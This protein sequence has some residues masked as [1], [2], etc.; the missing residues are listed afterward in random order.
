MS[1]AHWLAMGPIL[2]LW[3]MAALTPRE[4]Q[5]GGYL[6]A[7]TTITLAQLV[8]AL[9]MSAAIRLPRFQA[10]PDWLSLQLAILVFTGA[11]LLAA[12]RYERG[13]LV[14]ASPALLRD[15]WLATASDSW[16]LGS[17]AGNLLLG[18]APW[19]LT[20]ASLERSPSKLAVALAVLAVMTFAFINGGRSAMLVALGLPVTGVLLFA[21]PDRLR[22]AIACLCAAALLALLGAA[23]VFAARAGRSGAE[24]QE[25]LLALAR[26]LGGDWMEVPPRGLVAWMMACN[27]YL[28]HSVWTFADLLL[29]T[30]TPEGQATGVMWASIAGCFVVIDIPPN[31]LG[32]RFLPLIGCLIHDFGALLGTASWV[33]FWLGASMLSRLWTRWVPVHLLIILFGSIALLAPMM[34]PVDLSIMPATTMCLVPTALLL[35]WQSSARPEATS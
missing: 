9:S 5:S 16:S 28:L 24:S 8:P 13:L 18:F 34:N 10:L 29:G 22:K 7:L 3:V 15:A 1:R 32:G 17:A 14:A 31:G 33:S 4:P 27:L 2:M 12:D 19:S 30:L 23:A 20:V 11:C 35:T 21:N 25:F 26:H 6:V